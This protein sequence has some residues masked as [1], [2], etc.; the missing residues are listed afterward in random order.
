MN[1]FLVVMVIANLVQ[2][3][4][5]DTKK[6]ISEAKYCILIATVLYCCAL[7]VGWAYSD[8]FPFFLE[9]VRKLAE[10]FMGQNA[11]T[12]TFKI[13]AR[14]LIA[15]YLTMCLLVLFGTF[16]AFAAVFNGLIL[17]WVI[18]K[19]SGVL[20][21]KI[22][23]MLVP[24]GVFEWPAMMIGW[25]I[26]IWRGFGYRFSEPRSSSMER[27]KKANI[28]FLTIVL[29]LLFFAAIIEGRHLILKEF[30]H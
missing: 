21:S 18:A 14:N 7:V 2:K 4:F 9:Q 3:L 8:N 30:I 26:G 27:W 13:F 24:H 15:T 29:P 10:Q 11:L 1:T 28:V 22:A 12:F 17:G 5:S 23:I 20:G 19:A 25:G 6:T 16:P